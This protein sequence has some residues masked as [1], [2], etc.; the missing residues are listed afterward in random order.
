M[1]AVTTARLPHRFDKRYRLDIG[2]QN[3]ITATLL[4]SY[5]Q[6][7][8]R[9]SEASGLKH[10]GVREESRLCTHKLTL[11]QTDTDDL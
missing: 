6:H 11:S 7:K 2:R 3:Q 8:R 9:I 5:N 10:S 1:E 4:S